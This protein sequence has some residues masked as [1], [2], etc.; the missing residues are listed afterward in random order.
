MKS[1]LD[2]LEIWS[3]FNL[4]LQSILTLDED[5]RVNNVIIWKYSA[6]SSRVELVDLLVHELE[7]K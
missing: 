7:E 1:H 4:T 2:K 6:L 3:G 5:W